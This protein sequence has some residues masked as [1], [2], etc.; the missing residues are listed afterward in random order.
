MLILNPKGGWNDPLS[1]FVGVLA[2]LAILAFFG[3]GWFNA[4]KTKEARRETGQVVVGTVAKSGVVLV[5]VL[6][7]IAMAKGCE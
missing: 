7:V 5:V 2:I 6:V 1:A 3:W 4:M